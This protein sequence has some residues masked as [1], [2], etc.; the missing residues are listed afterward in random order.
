MS[1]SEP[2]GLI[3]LPVAFR[4]KIVEKIEAGRKEKLVV[5]RRFPPTSSITTQRGKLTLDLLLLPLLP[6]LP[7]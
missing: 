3:E 2:K 4:F 1:P 5:W 7:L 6:F